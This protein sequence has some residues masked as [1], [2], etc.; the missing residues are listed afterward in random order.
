M[1]WTPISGT[2]TQYQTSTGDLASNYYLKFYQSGTTT[3][4]N[5]ATDSTGG[6]TLD[7]CQLDSSGYPT[8]D[9]STRFIPHVNQ[10]YK[11]VLYKNSTDADANT[12]GNADWVIDAIPQTQTGDTDAWVLFSG[13]PTQTSAT[14]FTLTGDQTSAF[15]VGTRIKADDSSTLYGIVTASAFAT[16]TTVTVTLDSGSL[17][18]SLSAVYTGLSTTAG[19]EVSANTVSFLEQDI[20]TAV[21]YRVSQLLGELPMSIKLTGAV[22]DGSNVDGA[23]IQAVIDASDA[24][25]PSSNGLSVVYCPPGTYL[26]NTVITTRSATFKM[27]GPGMGRAAFKAGSSFPTTG[28]RGV[29]EIPADGQ[30]LEIDGI[31][32][33][34]DSK[35]QYGILT[36]VTGAAS[37]DRKH[38]VIK[39]TQVVKATE[40]CFAIASWMLT[41]EQCR[42]GGNDTS[43]VIFDIGKI[44]VNGTTSSREGTTTYLSN[45]YA[46]QAQDYAYRFT[47]I[48]GMVMDACGADN[49]D[50]DNETYVFRFE[51]TLAT[52]NG[53]DTEQNNRL[54]DL[55]GSATRVTV[56]NSR[57][58]GNGSVAST[59][60]LI[61]LSGGR[62]DL[63]NTNLDTASVGGNVTN[64][65]QAGASG[66]RVTFDQSS[67]DLASSTNSLT[68]TDQLM[69][70]D[71]VQAA[72]VHRNGADQTGI[73]TATET[74]LELNSEDY[75]IGSHY[76]AST[77]YD[78]TIPATGFYRI[79]GHV[80]II[81]LG[82][83][84]FVQARIKSGASQ[85]YKA[86]AHNSSS[87]GERTTVMIDYTAHFSKSEVLTFYV[88]HNHG[89][90][91]DIEGDKD[92]TRI[93]IERLK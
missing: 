35:A 60:Q 61:Q 5:M 59:T 89:S 69:C 20:A 15:T 24:K 41:M 14:T 42:G 46:L 23:L 13:T 53:V 71:P 62:L 32:I 22:G 86:Y 84:K 34:C 3:A 74:K 16:V 79:T 33:D 36:P 93:T 76:D 80:E 50:Y 51:N 1:A 88:Y 91:R 72:S 92:A 17:S 85:I 38:V 49:N 25:D 48:A 78:Y 11:I 40:V 6:T 19:M 87:A 70:V 68:T 37:D 66:V 39:N 12:V 9:G 90:N 82:D 52:L 45:C 67:T 56:N 54:F 65:V 21:I 73:V 58:T 55:S 2:M 8:T 30:F 4:F 75:D 29:I 31:N 57:F 43:K 10:K 64:C 81:D 83:Q 47:N 77:N 18:G 7:K 63:R 44:T 28:H 26:T 27:M